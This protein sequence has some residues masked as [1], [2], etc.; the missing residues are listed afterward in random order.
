MKRLILAIAAGLMAGSI[1]PLSI[2]AQSS[3]KAQETKAGSAM[4]APAKIDQKAVDAAQVEFKTGEYLEAEKDLRAVVTAI[5][6]DNSPTNPLK[7]QLRECLEALI[8]VEHRLGHNEEARQHSLQY[9]QFVS[10]LFAD[11]RTRRDPLLDQNAMEL[12]DIYVALD[13]AVD[14]EK[15][16]QSQLGQAEKYVTANPLRVL[17]LR[18]KLA[19]LADAQ[20][21]DA[22]ARGYWQQAI[23]LGAQTIKRF[24]GKQL[25]DTEFPRCAEALSKGYVATNQIS[26]VIDVYSA[27][28]D[29]QLKRLHNEQAA[30]EA[31]IVVASHRAKLG[32]FADARKLFED[33]L[34]QP[35]LLAKSGREAE[36]C[37]LLAAVYEAQGLQSEARKR[38][39]M[40][41]AID[42]QKLRPIQKNPNC[43]AQAMDL[44][45]SMQ[46][47]LRQSQ[48]YRE[49]VDACQDLL[50]AR[51]A[52]LGDAHPLTIAAKA[53]LGALYGQMENY[54]AAQPLLKAAYD[55]WTDRKPPAPLQ[56]ARALN[57]LAVVER[58]VGS[59]ADAKQHLQSALDLRKNNLEKND[60]RLAQSYMN[61]A[62]VLL[63]QAN[64]SQSVVLLEQAAEIYRHHGEIAQEPLSKTLLNE[65]RVFKS[66]GLL[67]K[68][69]EYCQA[70]LALGQK[71]SGIDAPST[72]EH[73]ITLAGL[74]IAQAK[75][76]DK[77]KPERKQLFSE[78]ESNSRRAW[79]LC[80]SNHLDQEPIAGAALYQKA[81]VEYQLGQTSAAKQDW[82]MALK[83]QR[84][85]GQK[86]QEAETLNYLAS[87]AAEGGKAAD[88]EPFY[89]QALK[90]QA[91]AEAHPEAFYITSCK[92]AEILHEQ[93]KTDEAS[94]LIQDAVKMLEQPRAQSVGGEAERAQYFSEFGAAYDLLVEWN[95]EPA[96]LNVDKAFEYAERGR[97]RTFL[98]QLSLVGVDLRDTAS[99]ELREKEQ[100]LRSKFASLQAE[101]RVAEPGAAANAL[102]QQLTKTQQEYAQVI[103][104]IHNASPY[105]REQLSQ[106]GQFGSLKALRGQLDKLS[107]MMLFYYVGAERSYLLVIDRDDQKTEVVPLEIPAVLAGAMSVEAGP[108]TRKK[109]ATIVNQYLADVRDRAGGRGLTGIVHGD[110]GVLASEQGTVLAEV[111]VPRTVRSMV[112]R[113]GPKCVVIV[114]D[115]ALHELPFDALLIERNPAPKYLLEVFP[116]I[117]YAPSAN[118]LVNLIGRPTDAKAVATLTVGNPKYPN[119]PAVPV[120]Q[121]SVADVTR[122][123]YLRLLGGGLPPLA[124]TA[125]EC[126]RIVRAFQG[127]KINDLEAEQA[128][129]GKLRKNLPGCRFIHVAAHGLVDQQSENLFGAIALTPPATPSDSTDDGF[130]S[131]NEIFNLPLSGCELVALSACQTNVGPDRPLEA[132]S[133]IAQAFLAAGARRAVCSHWNVDDKSTAELMGT[134][135]EKIASE[136]KAAD[137]ITYAAA[138]HEAQLKVRG[139]SKWSSPYYW[140]PFVLIGPPQ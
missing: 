8:S 92:L 64:Y 102:I 121:R 119:A 88:A 124:A 120:A 103:T 49:A 113:R 36:V 127:S 33:I 132:G 29:F 53:D 16:V 12:A 112:E 38:W 93:G 99:K 134:F 61:L 28:H 1:A 118:I 129:E 26:A 138:L 86:S 40:A 6:A 7:N 110:A 42:A 11:D 45:N 87:L 122:A 20:D 131:V 34:A 97:N 68:A 21:D 109:M 32:Q 116:P 46:I 9:Q 82:Q 72:I 123:A 84:D 125:E 4:I 43:R 115:G 27:L 44:L 90:M 80:Q 81:R 25:P 48:H 19:E 37:S 135:F 30:M 76:L 77:S 58:G 73:Y 126:K 10:R 56:L 111:L 54:E 31:Q 85:H 13:R 65:A 100:T 89:R 107:S 14:G 47:A 78:A 133:T 106:P 23:A 96:H 70:S 117:A 55:Y 2:R 50:A 79:E 51:Q 5:S 60:M 75:L 108:I 15:V 39:E 105:Y 95:L 140:A 67:A 35:K 63:D 128:T 18:V 66:Q 24:D 130:L 22:K 137:P 59:F 136:T 62:S 139:Q 57:D 52:A 41:A 17:D 74:S 114:P 71:V 3:A 104:D 101:A 98:D 91:A 69:A 94:N 83:I